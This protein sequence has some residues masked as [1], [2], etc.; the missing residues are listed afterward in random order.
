MSDT[1]LYTDNYG[2]HK[3]NVWNGQVKTCCGHN[4][5]SHEIQS[6]GISSLNRLWRMV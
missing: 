5:T 6:V 1:M 2:P 3:F 4:K